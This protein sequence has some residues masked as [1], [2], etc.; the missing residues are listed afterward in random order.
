MTTSLW[1]LGATQLTAGFRDGAFTVAVEAGVPI[2]PL[3]LI[4]TRDALVKHDWR[5]GSSDA[6]VRVLDPIEVDATTDVAD[7][8]DRTRAN[9]RRL[10]GE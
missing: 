6:E 3:A 10:M 7:L 9:A 4:G 1:Q 2:L 5:F 8:R